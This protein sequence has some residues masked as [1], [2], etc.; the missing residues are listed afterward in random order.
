MKD[1]QIFCDS[2]CDTPEHILKQHNITLIPF[3]ISFDKEHYEKEIEEISI[4]DFY[5]KLTASKIF[6]KTSLPS[7]QDYINHFQ[8]AL[9][10]GKDILC[11]CLSSIF[12]GSYQSALNAKLIL[13]EDYHDAKI[14]IIDSMQATSCEG[15]TVLQAAYMKEAGYSLDKTQTTLEKLRSTS[16]I[17]FTVGTLEYLQKGG[18][19]GKVS[20]LAGT[21]LNLKPLI[22]LRDGELLP[23]GTIRGRNKSLEKALLMVKDYFEENGESFD[24]YD[25][26]VTTGTAKDEAEKF[27]ASLEKLIGRKIPYPIFT[28]GVTI[29][30]NTGPD[31]IGACF[32][33]K[34]N[35]I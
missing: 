35:R 22:Q 34:Y 16:R 28:I 30:T 33:K 3:Y 4:P 18:R 26:V 11:I 29:G 5:V 6:P 1:Y 14:V 13:E 31:A 12:S 32:I 24:D 21:M 10:S 25:F 7:V 20:S 17:M 27:K 9:D 8:K 2:S 19:I 23:Y 15:L